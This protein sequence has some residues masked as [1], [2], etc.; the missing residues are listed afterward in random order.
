MSFHEIIIP[1]KKYIPHLVAVLSLGVVFVP[2]KVSFAQ[3]VGQYT[4][5][6]ETAEEEELEVI[7]ARVF[8]SKFETPKRGEA[9]D[10]LYHNLNATLAAFSAI[11]DSFKGQLWE[12]MQPYKFQLT[13]RPDE[14]KPSLDKALEGLNDNYKSM[15]KAISNYEQES[16]QIIDRLPEAD[17]ETAEGIWKDTLTSFKGKSDKYFKLQH[18]YLATYRGLVKFILSQNGSYYYDSPTDKIGFYGFGVYNKYA[19]M[20]DKIN[21]IHFEQGVIARKNIYGSMIVT[22]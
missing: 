14:F 13:R 18:Q 22:D 10:R 8:S 9:L 11:D 4:P 20:V 5:A 6:K 1:M 16:K 7:V 17:K 21:K 19:N 12:L 3:I 2:A 15:Q